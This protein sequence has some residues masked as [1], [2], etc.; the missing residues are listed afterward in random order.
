MTP[1]GADGTRVIGGFEFLDATPAKAMEAW[2]RASEKQRRAILWDTPRLA[3]KNIL[4][5]L[6]ASAAIAKVA[7][8]DGEP[9]ALA[10]ASPMQM[11]S[12][13][14]QIHF[15]YCGRAGEK[16][17]IAAAAIAFMEC[18]LGRFSTLLCL[19]PAA[20]LGAARLL[21]GLGFEKGAVLKRCA[22]V[23]GRMRSC[24]FW[25]CNEKK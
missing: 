9:F 7:R 17:L 1:S 23:N 18:C 25:V 8:L 14:C 15:F 5:S 3:R 12:A 4:Q 10:W 21:A 16:E 22:R 6:I 11:E 24:R 2:E 13:T 20:Y 19:V